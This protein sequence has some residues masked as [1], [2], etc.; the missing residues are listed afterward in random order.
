MEIIN[1]IQDVREHL[2]V[3]QQRKEL[4]QPGQGFDYSGDEYKGVARRVVSRLHPERMR[5]RVTEIVQETSSTKT[6]RFERTDGPLPPFRAGQY[7]NLFADVDG[8]LTSRR[9]S[10]WRGA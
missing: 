6:L 9:A 3:S 1:W 2:R 10:T 5:L 7:V 4:R 8:V